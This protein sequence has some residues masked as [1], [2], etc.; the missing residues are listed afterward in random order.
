MLRFEELELGKVYINK[1]HDTP[2]TLIDVSPSSE[3]PYEVYAYYKDAEGFPWHRPLGLF[4]VK[5]RQQ[6]DLERITAGEILTDR[7]N[8]ARLGIKV[9]NGY[10]TSDLPDGFMVVKETEED[11]QIAGRFN[12]RIIDQKQKELTTWRYKAEEKFNARNS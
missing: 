5:F 1:K 12:K 9:P 11:F 7:D 4:M 8:T 2:Y 10:D 6:T 3:E